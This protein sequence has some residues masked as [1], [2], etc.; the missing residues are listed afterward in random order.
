MG[1]TYNTGVICNFQI[2]FFLSFK[3]DIL[4]QLLLITGVI[5]VFTLFSW[6]TLS[7]FIHV[8]LLSF[9]AQEFILLLSVLLPLSMPPLLPPPFLS[10]FVL[11]IVRAFTLNKILSFTLLYY[12][13]VT[14]VVA[15]LPPM[16]PPHCL[17]CRHNF[18]HVHAPG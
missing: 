16:W 10:Y 13:V 12:F 3:K 15:L 14:L 9:L 17:H 5:Y 4:H 8:I 11:F 6:L 7:F 18:V 2:N 1:I